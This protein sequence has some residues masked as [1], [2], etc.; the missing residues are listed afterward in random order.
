[1]VLPHVTSRQPLLQIAGVTQV[2]KV[3]IDQR[4]GVGGFIY[5]T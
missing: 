4:K 5:Q 1:M 3:A 2:V